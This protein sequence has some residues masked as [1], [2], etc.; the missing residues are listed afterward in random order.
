MSGCHVQARL[1]I[2][3]RLSWELETLKFKQERCQSSVRKQL[4]MHNW[5]GVNFHLALKTQGA[6]VHPRRSNSSW[7]KME[8]PSLRSREKEQS[9]SPYRRCQSE[10]PSK[11]Q[12]SKTS[13]LQKLTAF[14]SPAI[15]SS[16]ATEPFSKG[17]PTERAPSIPISV[18]T[19]LTT[20]I[21]SRTYLRRELTCPG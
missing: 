5:D 21:S 20:S 2:E 8:S 14:T 17:T 1:Q 10:Q 15:L 11:H 19:H 13:L 3:P 7:F 12:F 6:R 16:I 9:P 4:S 18:N